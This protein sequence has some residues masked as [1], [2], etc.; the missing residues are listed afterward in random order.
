MH[1]ALMGGGQAI[2]ID[3][4]SAPWSGPGHQE[5]RGEAIGVHERCR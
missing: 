4:E 5:G 1:R 3:P 2:V